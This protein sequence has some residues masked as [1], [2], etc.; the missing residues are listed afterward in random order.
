MSLEI[1][2]S[3]SFQKALEL[4]ALADD[5]LDYYREKMNNIQ[6]LLSRVQQLEDDKQAKRGQAHK[7][8][9]SASA[10]ASKSKLNST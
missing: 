1:G 3:H 5:E 2:G 4:L 8:P 7:L 9:P 10:M 6:F